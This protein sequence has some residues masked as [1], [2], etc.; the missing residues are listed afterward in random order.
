MAEEAP[1]VEK[2]LRM[3]PSTRHH[4]AVEREEETKGQG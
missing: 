1:G 3:Y 4:Y 2:Q